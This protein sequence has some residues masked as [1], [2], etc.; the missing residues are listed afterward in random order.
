MFSK[1]YIYKGGRT[2]RPVTTTTYDPKNS[3]NLNGDIQK[4]LKLLPQP[5]AENNSVAFAMSLVATT[6]AYITIYTMVG[7]E[8]T[9]ECDKEFEEQQKKYREWNR[10]INVNGDTINDLI[11]DIWIDNLVFSNYYG[12][13]AKNLRGIDNE[14]LPGVDVQ[15]MPP[16]T[17]RIETDSVMGWRKFI[18]RSYGRSAYK[19]PKQFLDANPKNLKIQHGEIVIPDDQRVVLHCSLFRKPPMDAVL[20]WIV[21]K[22]WTLVFMG[23]VSEKVWSNII[24]AYKG[25]PATNFY[26][27]SPQEMDEALED[28]TSTLVKLKNFSVGAFPGDTKVEVIQPKNNMSM[29]ADMIHLMDQEIMLGLFSS[30]ATRDGGSTKKDNSISDESTVRFLLGIRKKIENTIKRFYVMNLAP[31]PEEKIHFIW[32]ELR[33]TSVENIIKAIEVSGTLG[34]FTDAREKR[35]VM[36]QVL[37]W[38]TEYEITDEQLA[39]LEKQFMELNK[40][41]QPGEG[42]TT[43]KN[44]KT[45]AK[46]DG[47]E[48]GRKP[49]TSTK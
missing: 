17:I 29:Y 6:F 44:P 20:P 48:G 1:R 4:I 28:I 18:Q 27:N 2:N 47:A 14:I 21:L 32:P 25:D 40:P 43:T 30:I 7:E 46:T 13:V 31:M 38:L 8:V 10:R 19:T 22:Y 24:L 39:K 45:K 9:I 5:S 37:P 15:R 36:A 42:N 23:K 33:T 12:R 35:R 3:M 49:K 41:S 11:V 26:P 34:I 16:E